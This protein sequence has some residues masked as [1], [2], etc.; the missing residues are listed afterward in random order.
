MS[1]L[2][3]RGEGDKEGEAKFDFYTNYQYR[4]GT[5][6]FAIENLNNNDNNNNDNNN[7]K[8]NDNDN[9]IDS[10]KADDKDNDKD[11]DNDNDDDRK[12]IR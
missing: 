6:C 7:D 12:T 2:G 10:D 3:K 9:D 5:N 4:V 8:D 1:L 11:N